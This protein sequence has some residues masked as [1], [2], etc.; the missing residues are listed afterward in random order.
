[1]TLETVVQSS[2]DQVSCDLGG[3]AAILTLGI[4]AS[5]PIA[6]ARNP[7]VIS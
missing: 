4:H 7:S 5:A 3:E 6:G 1:V 2:P